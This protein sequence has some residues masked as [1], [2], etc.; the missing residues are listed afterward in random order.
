MLAVKYEELHWRVIAHL[1]TLAQ[2]ILSLALYTGMAALFNYLD[3]LRPICASA[4]A[5]EGGLG[6]TTDV[7]AYSLVFGGIIFIVYSYAGDLTSSKRSRS[8]CVNM[9]V[10]PADK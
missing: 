7:L 6:L 9:H 8:F 3:E 1:S 5:K 4:P 2:V 10:T